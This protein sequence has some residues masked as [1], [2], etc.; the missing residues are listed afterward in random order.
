MS[1]I[2]DFKIGER[3]IIE[4]PTYCNGDFVRY[5]KHTGIIISIM[6]SGFCAIDLGFGVIALRRSER[7]FKC[8]E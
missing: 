6:Q 4:K 7:I 2:H 1:N 8:E 3:V 5:E